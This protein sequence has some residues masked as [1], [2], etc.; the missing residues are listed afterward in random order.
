MSNPVDPA[1]S[2]AERGTYL[3]LGELSPLSPASPEYLGIGDSEDVEQEPVRQTSTIRDTL[4][5]YPLLSN[6]SG[7]S[8]SF[9]MPPVKPIALKKGI[10]N[11][12]GLLGSIKTPRVY[13][14]VCGVLIL[15]SALLIT[16]GIGCAQDPKGD[17]H[18]FG[19]L[20][21]YLAIP[22]VGFGLIFLGLT[23]VY[24]HHFFTQLSH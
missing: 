8:V 15:F 2:H 13:G 22:F 16:A 5:H 23:V 11:S 20:G 6:E 24:A 7:K 18:P 19:D 1:G 9:H 17:T 10:I 21:L 12:G 14:M 4:L 3:D